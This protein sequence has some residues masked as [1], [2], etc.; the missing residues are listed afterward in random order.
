MSVSA[1]VSVGSRLRARPWQAD[2]G[3]AHIAPA[4]DHLGPLTATD[5]DHAGER[6]PQQGYRAIT[7]AALH[8]PDRRPFTEAGFGET[9]RLHLLRHDLENV[10]P[11]PS[12]PG[13]EVRRGRRRDQDHAL[14]V[15]HEA[16]AP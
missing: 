13:I 7:T 9:E 2:A 5:L 10:P 3:I 16:F 15:D 6:L 8:R 4:V 1:P 11:A 14:E 12:T